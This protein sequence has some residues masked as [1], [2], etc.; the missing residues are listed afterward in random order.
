MTFQ[1]RSL[2]PLLLVTYQRGIKGV[3]AGSPQDCHCRREIVTIDL[4]TNLIF[5][6]SLAA[7]LRG[8]RVDKAQADGKFKSFL[9]GSIGSATSMEK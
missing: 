4:L 6:S 9:H 3:N 1:N 7:V 8:D 2:S 5:C